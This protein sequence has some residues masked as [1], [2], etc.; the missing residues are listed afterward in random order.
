MYGYYS[1]I[2]FK[3]SHKSFISV[4]SYRSHR[5]TQCL[6]A[7]NTKSTVEAVICQ[8]SGLNIFI[9]GVFIASFLAT[10]TIDSI[11]IHSFLHC[12]C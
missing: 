2:I 1:V 4:G 9:I 6:R 3:V 12:I 5:T 11:N 10:A 7:G 8:S